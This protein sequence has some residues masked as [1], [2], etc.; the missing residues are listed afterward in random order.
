MSDFGTLLEREPWFL[1]DANFLGLRDAKFWN[2]SVLLSDG[3]W[4]S[5]RRGEE[6]AG[7]AL[8]K[9]SPPTVTKRLS[10]TCLRT[11]EME[12]NLPFSK[13]QTLLLVS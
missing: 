5:Q 6:P 3:Q 13:S 2:E 10:P 9:A 12:K 8:K 1:G 7:V 11:A 4:L